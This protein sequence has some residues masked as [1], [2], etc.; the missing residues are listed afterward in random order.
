[1]PLLFPILA[2][3]AQLHP[4]ADF[5]TLVGVE[6][7]LHSFLALVGTPEYHVAFLRSPPRVA[8][9][10]SDRKSRPRRFFG[11]R[12][13]RGPEVPQ[14]QV[15]LLGRTPPGSRTSKKA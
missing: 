9:F 5:G 10:L 2:L 13:L 8:S 3:G 1:M 11:G 4:F 14:E 6:K 7:E 12:T 15:L